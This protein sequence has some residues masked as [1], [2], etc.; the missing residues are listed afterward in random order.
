MKAG[1]RLYISVPVEFSFGEC[2]GFLGRSTNES[3]FQVESDHV[4]RAF[5]TSKGDLLLDVSVSG[6]KISLQALKGNGDAE[7]VRTYINEWFDLDNDIRPF[8]A[9]AAKDKLLA[10]LAKR[11][12][13]LR[14]IGIPDLFEAFAW[15]VTG[16]QINLAF[17]YTL[18]RRLVEAFGGSMT[19]EGRK[20]FIFPD[21]QVIAGL[22]ISDLMPLQYSERKAEYLITIAQK[23]AS[24]E[25]SKDKLLAMSRGEVEQELVSIRGIGKWTA[26]YVMMKSLRD[27]SAFPVGDVG[28][29]NAIKHLLGLAAKPTPEEVAKLG[30]KWKGWEAYA[31]FYLWRSLY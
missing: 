29:Q 27:H 19:H 4:R 11:F 3:V 25:V 20:H 16:Q 22:N 15:A 17:A 8:Y 24:G 9:L 31:T 18:K 14:V 7:E 28:L 12:H 1:D 30:R 21:P 6:K 5:R 13:G 10:P 26:H 2:L 23:I